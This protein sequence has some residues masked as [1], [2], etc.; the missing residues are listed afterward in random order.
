M[1]NE[2]NIDIQRT[3][4]PVRIGTAELWFDSSLENLRRF[5]DVEELANKK[6]KEA[7][8][9]AQHIHFPD[10]VDPDNIDIESVDAAIDVNKEFIAAQYDVI[11]GDGTFKK[12]YKVYPDILALE[13]VLETVGKMI[14]E[15]IEE[16]ET[17]RSEL[18][19]SK[20]AEYLTKKAA[21][22]V[23][24]A[25]DEKVAEAVDRIVAD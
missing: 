19:E 16:L 18:I 4:F 12:I 3:G 6:L 9:K 23:K 7:Q 1:T 24:G 21:K 20:K 25:I 15:R 11:F 22:K 14:A 8:E 10:D 2:I 13:D 17:V 5:F